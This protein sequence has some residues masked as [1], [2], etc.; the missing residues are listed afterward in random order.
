MKSDFI[1]SQLDREE[2][3][4]FGL[5]WRQLNVQQ[6]EDLLDLPV[7]EY[8]KNRL[9]AL[10]Q[11]QRQ[12]PQN[13]QA[14]RFSGSGAKAKIISVQF[15]INSKFNTSTKRLNFIRNRLNVNPIK[16]AH[17]MGNFIAYRISESDSSK[18]HFTKK[19][20][21]VNIIFEI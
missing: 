17:N 5:L 9:H 12:Q 1:Y 16:K 3:R 20:N 21:D 6:K 15:P 19:N 10:V 7:M 2:R 14:A 13:A 11:S 18:N 8:E 4:K